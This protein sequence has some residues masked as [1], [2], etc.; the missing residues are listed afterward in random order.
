MILKK[1]D[2][3]IQGWTSDLKKNE[4]KLWSVATSLF[5]VRRS[6]LDVGR[7]FFNIFNVLL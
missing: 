6:M 7:S 4:I 1:R 5:D 3:V 2:I